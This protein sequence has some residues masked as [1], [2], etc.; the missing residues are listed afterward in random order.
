MTAA[1]AA[2]AYL[3]AQ[4]PHVYHA[5]PLTSKSTYTQS[6]QVIDHG[7]TFVHAPVVHH[8]PLVHTKTTL[9]KA[10]QVVNHGGSAVFHPVNTYEVMPV[11]GIYHVPSKTTVTKS[12]QV[13]NHGG[14]AVVHAPVAH[15]TVVHT[16]VVYHSSPLVTL[17]T[18]DSAISHQSS[19][20]HETVPVV[21]SLPFVAI[22]H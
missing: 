15:A 13:V 20:V 6:S 14:T 18:G 10:N 11:H 19:T 4:D 21:K 3:L 1:A 8:V 12:S 2:P 5:L 7:S 9:T 22:H 17:K 16:P